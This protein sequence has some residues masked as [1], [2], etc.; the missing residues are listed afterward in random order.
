MF[1]LPFFQVFLLPPIQAILLPLLAP[2]RSWPRLFF[3]LRA[4]F[5]FMM[6]SLP[7]MPGS[8]N[9]IHERERK[10]RRSKV[11][12]GF[13][14]D[15]GARW[16]KESGMAAATSDIFFFLK[17]SRRR[18]TLSE[19]WNNRRWH[20]QIQMNIWHPSCPRPCCQFELIKFR[21]FAIF[22]IMLLPRL[23]VLTLTKLLRNIPNCLHCGGK[24]DG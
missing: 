10:R 7:C 24:T 3:L 8:P 12:E 23:P 4:P 16:N 22:G 15:I 1:S 18:I 21:T 11:E 9:E 2:L 20:K 13:R 14:A 19:F 5:P 17:T 6:T